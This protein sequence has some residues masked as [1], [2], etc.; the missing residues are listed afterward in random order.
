MI[1]VLCI[2]SG[3]E[4]TC[5]LRGPSLRVCSHLTVMTCAAGAPLIS[6][7]RAVELACALMDN[8]LEVVETKTYKKY[9]AN[10]TDATLVLRM[11]AAAK[12]K[13]KA[14]DPY[15]LAVVADKKN[16]GAYT[17]AYDPF[18]DGM[19]LD[20][21]IGAPVGNTLAPKFLQHYHM[22]CDILAAREV[23]D[24]ITFA[25]QQ[26]GSY[27]STIKTQERLRV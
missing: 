24:E 8:E 3:R 5:E 7:L 19:G 9:G 1:P 26:D 4:C 10:G 18:V 6:D 11:S 13:Y 15:E 20:R 2:E 12:T 14:T 17:L 21:V 22:A 16:K 27:M 23:G 25:K